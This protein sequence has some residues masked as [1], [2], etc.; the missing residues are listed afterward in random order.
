MVGKLL[1]CVNQTWESDHSHTFNISHTQTVQT[2][3]LLWKLSDHLEKYQICYLDVF[4]LNKTLIN[5]DA[6]SEHHHHHASSQH[7]VMITALQSELPNVNIMTMRAWSSRSLTS[8]QLHATPPS[9]LQMSAAVSDSSDS[10]TLQHF[11]KTFQWRDMKCLISF[12][13]FIVCM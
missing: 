8:H 4:F 6:S 13:Q 3:Q 9:L 10:T 12:F 1:L 7:P 5:H 2:V 11:T